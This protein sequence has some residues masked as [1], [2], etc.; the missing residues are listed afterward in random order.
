MKISNKL[1]ALLAVFGL[2]A[3]AA[4]EQDHTPTA[5][6]LQAINDQLEAASGHQAIVDDLNNQLSAKDQ[7]I[8]DLE[9]KVTALENGSGAAPRAGGADDVITD[10]PEADSD[11]SETDA[12]LKAMRSD[13]GIE[14]KTD[15]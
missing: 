4:E 13:L 11:L 12:Q 7:S 14:T 15:K 1:T 8:S 10:G 2:S 5:E 3:A 6:Q 9:A